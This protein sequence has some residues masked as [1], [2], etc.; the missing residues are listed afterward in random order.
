MYNER[1]Q[2]EEAGPAMPGVNARNERCAER[3]R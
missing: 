2:R 1:G 3:R